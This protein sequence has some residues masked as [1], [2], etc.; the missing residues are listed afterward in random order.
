MPV[1]VTSLKN[2]FGDYRL[3][4]SGKI[5]L[6]VIK[7]NIMYLEDIKIFNRPLLIVDARGRNTFS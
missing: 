2:H 4:F 1:V 7:I 6:K 3:V 5:K